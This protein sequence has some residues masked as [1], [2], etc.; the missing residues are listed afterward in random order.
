MCIRDS[1]YS[2]EVANFVRD[3]LLYG[4]DDIELTLKHLN[5]I[6]IYE[7]KKFNNKTWKTLK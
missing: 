6:E 4:Y 2:F 5:S 7:K 3:R 1:A